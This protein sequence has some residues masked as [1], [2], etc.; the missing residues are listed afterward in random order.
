MQYRVETRLGTK[1]Y[2]GLVTLR[3]DEETR[4]DVQ[5]PETVEIPPEANRDREGDSPDTGGLLSYRWV[6]NWQIE[7]ILPNAIRTG[8][9]RV[10][11]RRVRYINNPNWYN[12]Q[13]LWT[14]YYT[15]TVGRISGTT[16]G[17][18][19]GSWLGVPGQFLEIEFRYDNNTYLVR[20]D[21]S[22]NPF[23]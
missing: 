6:N 16:N 9:T 5:I 10:I 12:S 1:S 19:Y 8:S 18:Y 22:N 20:I 15:R 11:E 4:P 3:E 14:L 23:N 2:L 17:V 13:P 21:G 7:I